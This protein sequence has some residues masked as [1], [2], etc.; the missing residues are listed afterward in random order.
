[1]NGGIQNAKI[2]QGVFSSIHTK[3]PKSKKLVLSSLIG[4]HALHANMLHALHAGRSFAA[5]NTS[6]VCC[7]LAIVQPEVNKH[8]RVQVG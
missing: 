7:L 8:G 1:L 3:M 4:T 6:V 5:N 2:F